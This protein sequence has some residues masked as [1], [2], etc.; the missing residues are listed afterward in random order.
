MNSFEQL[1]TD[2][3]AEVLHYASEELWAGRSPES[4]EVRLTELHGLNTPAANKVVRIV[5]HM[6]KL[7]E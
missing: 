1:T 2:D 5:Q 6:H 3:L 7:S 4:I